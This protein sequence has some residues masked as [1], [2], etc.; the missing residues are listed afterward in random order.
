MIVQEALK[1]GAYD[2]KK[3]ANRNL[4]TAFGIT[5]GL[6]LLLALAG[7]AFFDGASITGTNA[8]VIGPPVELIDFEKKELPQVIKTNRTPSPPPSLLPPEIKNILGTGPADAIGDLNPSDSTFDGPEIAG[9]E[10]M[11]HA[12]NIGGGNGGFVEEIDPTKIKTG[13]V[14]PPRTDEIST[15]PDYVDGYISDGQK[16]TYSTGQLQSNIAY[17]SLER[18]VGEEGQVILKVWLSKTGTIDKIEV[19]KGRGNFID[20]ARQAINKT[21]F[22]PATQQG[23]AVRSKLVVTVDFKLK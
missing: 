21:T 20:A 19:V 23:H 9:I 18:E 1:L 14:L 12:N 7:G 8:S 16:A 3:H 10:E 17:P 11:V 22:A 13:I 6:V 5:L 2:L 4:S 15:E